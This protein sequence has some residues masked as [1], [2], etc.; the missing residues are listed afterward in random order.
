MT[1]RVVIADDHPVIVEGVRRHLVR[2]EGI[3]VLAS[4]NSF[5]E[6]SAHLDQELPDVVV[7]DVQM[8]GVKGRASMQELV[9]RGVR[10]ILFTL[11]SPDALVANLAS[12]GAS[13][14][15]S[16]SSTL[17]ALELAIRE[18]H[19]GNEVLPEE[20][21]ALMKEVGAAP[22]ETLT[23][24]EYQVFEQLV[25]CQTP[26]EIAFDIGVSLSTVYTHV[27]RVRTKLKLSHVSE[28][29]RYAREWGF[30]D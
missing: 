27:E 25:A 10:V 1:V 28:V 24:R 26:K 19:K 30:V 17:D 13:G 20:L 15:V 11:R 22:H 5:E 8:P 4:G 14:Y 9:A 23:K 18:V 29:G 3:E 21:R 12:G 2:V 7:M 6:L 16:K